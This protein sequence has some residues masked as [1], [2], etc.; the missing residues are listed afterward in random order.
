MEVTERKDIYKAILITTVT[1]IGLFYVFFAEFW[2]FSF[3]PK[4]LVTPLI[5][6]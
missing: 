2:L 1:F 4:N 5:T 3:G 6:D